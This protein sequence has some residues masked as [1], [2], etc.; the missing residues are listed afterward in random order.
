MDGNVRLKALWE[1][2]WCFAVLLI[3]FFMALPELPEFIDMLM[4]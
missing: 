2:S 4:S 3:L 1:L